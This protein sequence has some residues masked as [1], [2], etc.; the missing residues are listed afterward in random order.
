MI[1]KLVKVPN[2]KFLQNLEWL[3]G[4]MEKVNLWPYVN[5]SYELVW[6]KI[7]LAYQLLVKSQNLWNIYMCVYVRMECFSWTVYVFL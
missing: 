7:R 6:P 4:Y 1:Y 5:F 3:E 2:I